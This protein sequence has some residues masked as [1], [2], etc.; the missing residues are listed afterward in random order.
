MRIVVFGA[1][2]LVGTA[3]VERLEARG[4]DVVPVI[5]GSGSAWRLARTG[6]PLATADLLDR[7]SVAV[8][9]RGATHVVNCSRGDH[10]VMREGLLNLLRESRRADVKKFLHL[11]SV[12]IYGNSPGADCVHED[13][14]ATPT[15]GTYGALKLEQDGMV[16]TAAR[17]GLQS[18]ILC[19]PNISG[20]HS[21]FL[22]QVRQ[23]LAARRFAVVEGGTSPCNL[24]DVEN[25]AYAVEC[26][27]D[28][29]VGEAQRYFVTD[30][31]SISWNDVIEEL[32]QTIKE[33]TQPPNISREQIVEGMRKPAPR[34]RWSRT[35]LHPLSGDVRTAIRQDPGWAAM[36]SAVKGALRRSPPS[37]WRGLQ[38][39]VAGPRTIKMAGTEAA[40][41]LALVAQQLRGI[42]H[43][44]ERAHK[45]LGYSPI[46]SFESS[47]RA[48]RKWYS[49]L[50]ST[51]G[52]DL[53]I[54]G[55]LQ[56][57]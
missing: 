35:F 25:L 4:R 38:R 57:S 19:P 33:W 23:S 56:Q 29:D 50:I 34:R 55:E 53:Q 8:A 24:V 17:Q 10:A 32:R 36:E 9:L 3:V 30:H 28:A 52:D 45:D 26:A 44:C 11:S 39:I 31:A 18:V 15:P 37:L 49:Q 42:R 7:R 48:F 20:P 5:H 51:D 1:S 27:L 46:V 14:R 12:A 41:D 6:R 16:R 22:L 40:W 54:L 47:M 2:G 13:G 21:Y 43:S